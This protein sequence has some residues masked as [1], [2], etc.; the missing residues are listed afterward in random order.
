MLVGFRDGRAD[1]AF[2]GGGVGGRLDG[3][4]GADE[5]CKSSGDLDGE[6]VGAFVDRGVV[7]GNNGA[8]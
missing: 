3:L 7:T 1:G 5:I 8:S 2:D 4:A 6:G